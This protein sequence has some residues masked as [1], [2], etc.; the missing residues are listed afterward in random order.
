MNN[1]HYLST[2]S[3]ILCLLGCTNSTD[4]QITSVSEKS[5]SSSKYDFDIN[6]RSETEIL[7][8]E[9]ELSCQ[10]AMSF[11]ADSMELLSIN[12][13]ETVN[14]TDL[15][16]LTILTKSHQSQIEF[17]VNNKRLTSKRILGT[18]QRSSYPKAEKHCSMLHNTLLVLSAHMVRLRT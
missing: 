18:E 15:E 16:S 17:M 1:F 14:S 8:Y 12:L 10:N 4:Y 6:F 11:S 2:L 3:L 9:L 5:G 7:F 13:L